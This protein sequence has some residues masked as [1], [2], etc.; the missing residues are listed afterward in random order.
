MKLLGNSITCLIDYLH[1]RLENAE[2]HALV[3]KRTK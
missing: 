1:L 2:R 3:G